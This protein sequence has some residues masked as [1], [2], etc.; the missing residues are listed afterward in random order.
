M[1]RK[2][3]VYLDGGPGNGLTL[4]V[5]QPDWGLLPTLRLA[6]NGVNVVYVRAKQRQPQ[7]GRPWRYVPKNAIRPL[8]YT[9][10]G[11]LNNPYDD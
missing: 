11:A 3:L 5:D 4:K 10:P 6:I 8:R 9:S 7:R 1:G 2:A